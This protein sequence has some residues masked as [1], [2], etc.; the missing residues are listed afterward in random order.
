MLESIFN[1]RTQSLLNKSLDVSSLRNEV[2]A[3]NIANVGTPDFKRSEVLFEDKIKKVLESQTNYAK[4]NTTNSR[5]IQIIPNN[6]LQDV[7]PEVTTLNDLSYR[8]DKNNVD[9]DVE[10]AKMAKNSIWYDTL[11]RCMGDEISIL[12]LAITGRR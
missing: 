4:L 7:E 3:N 6:N 12:R 1:S 9:I 11:S 8:N 10:N 5:H 2:I